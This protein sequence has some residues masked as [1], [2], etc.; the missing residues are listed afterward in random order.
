MNKLQQQLMV[1][2]MQQKQQENKVE[3]MQDEAKRVF[4]IIQLVYQRLQ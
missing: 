2:R 4:D 3:E 1:L